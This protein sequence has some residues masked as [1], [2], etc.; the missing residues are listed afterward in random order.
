MSCINLH[1]NSTV[2][3]LM[4]PPTHTVS[5]ERKWFTKEEAVSMLKIRSPIKCKYLEAACFSTSN[6]LIHP[7]TSNG[8]TPAVRT[9]NYSNPRSSNPS[10]YHS[11]VV[12]GVRLNCSDSGLET[13]SSNN[14]S[15]YCSH[16]NCSCQDSCSKDECSQ[17]ST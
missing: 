17:D 13:R 6:T 2:P 4:S 14:N 5:R 11:R 9:N 10:G 8:D 12:D 7:T 15:E 3:V 1:Y 16:G